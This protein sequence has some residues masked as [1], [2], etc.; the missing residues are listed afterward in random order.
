MESCASPPS[1]PLTDQRDSVSASSIRLASGRASALKATRLALTWGFEHLNLRRVSLS[2]LADN[3]RAVAAY[4]RC[5]F[6]VEG[7]HRDTLLRDGAWHDDLTMAILKPQWT[8]Q[9]AGTHMQ[10]TSEAP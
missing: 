1:T 9:Q 6:T 10:V 8:S 2:V 7:R 3:S 4:T 5:G